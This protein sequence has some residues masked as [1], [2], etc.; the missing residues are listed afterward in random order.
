MEVSQKIKNRV[1]IW[2]SNPSSGYLPEQFWEHY[3]QRCMHPCV[4]CSVIH[5]DKDMK[6]TEVSFDRWLDR[7]D[8]LH[9]CNGILL[10]YKK[11]WNTAICNSMDGPW[12]YYARQ[13]KSVRKS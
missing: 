7:D 10:S 6:T 8:M 1:T 4:H 11:R 13:N 3:L 9:M 5:G 12:E 2:P